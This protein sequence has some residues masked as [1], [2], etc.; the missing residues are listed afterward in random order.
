[1]KKFSLFALF[2]ILA[3]CASAGDTWTLRGVEYQVD[4]LFHNQVGPGTTQTSLWFH[5]ETGKLRVFYCTIDMTNPWLSLAGVCATDK[6]AGNE[7]VSAMAERKSEPGKRYFAGINADFFNTSG[8]TGRGVSIV[9][10]P[11]GATVVDGEI[12]RAR[13]NA[14]LYKNFIVDENEMVYV[15]PFVFGGTLTTPAGLAATLGGVNTYSSENNNKIV[16]YTDR[17]YGSTDQT[18]AGTELVARLVEGDKFESAKPYRMVVES[19]TCTAG[20]M[21]IPAGK[22]VIRGRGSAATVVNTLLVGD[23]ITISPTWTFGDLSV[24]PEQVISGNPKILGD[25]VVLDSEGERPDASQLHPRSAVGYSDGG[26]KVY[27]LVVDGRSLIS[28]GVR[29]SVL[30]DIMRYAGATDAMNVDGGGSSTLYTSALGV[31]NMPSDGTER[32]DGNGFFAVCNAPDDDVIASLRFVDFSLVVPKFGIYTPKFYGYNQYGMLIDTDVQGVELSCDESL[33]TIRDGN[34]IFASGSGTAMLTGTL[35]DVSVSA[36]LTIIGSGDA[37]ELKNDSIITDTYRTH[38]VALQSRVGENMMPLDP[39]ALTWCSSD[40][41]IVVIDEN[42]GVLQGVRDGEASVTGTINEQSVTMKVTV[43]KPVQRIYAIDPEMDLNTWTFNISGGKNLVV[44][45]LENGVKVDFTG[46]SGRTC[47]LRMNKEIV[48]WSIPDTLRVRIN[49]GEVSVTGVT[50]AL[51]PNGGKISYQAVSPDSVPANV[52]STIDLPID[53]WID[54]DDMGN[55]PIQLNYVQ[56]S[57]GKPTAGQQY[58][59]LI[60]GLE[61]I[62]R[63]APLTVVIPGDVDGNGVVTAA[64]VT[65]LYDFLLND[66]TTHLVNGDQT[67]DGI[68]TAADVTAVYDILLGS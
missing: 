62:Y 49:P 40:E 47:Y 3:I 68:I 58:T 35:G 36:P 27:F 37:I 11:V 31:R 23:T 43:Q 59:M 14:A 44:E 41:S 8:T 50:F 64:D 7:K 9:G 21:T 42:T 53:Q 51:R 18:N 39:E 52:E 30:A 26:S 33:G 45:P 57:M 46:S 4:T 66:A 60:P 5:N 16:I 17:Y 24:V 10:T 15:N 48:L 32:A 55:Y 20:D 67:G 61:S 2:A 29:T 65:A 63:Y 34:T 25:G 6:L 19:D 28:D 56:I 54:A 38:R 1:M 13:N 22:Y 12:Y